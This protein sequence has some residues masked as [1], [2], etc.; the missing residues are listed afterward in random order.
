M[1]CFI[2]SNKV[3]R[4]ETGNNYAAGNRHRIRHLSDLVSAQL[5]RLALVKRLSFAL[6][7]TRFLWTGWFWHG[8]LAGLINAPLPHYFTD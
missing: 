3:E 8:Q 5:V 4:A 7:E 1:S 6:P 2:L